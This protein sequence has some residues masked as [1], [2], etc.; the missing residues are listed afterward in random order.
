MKND[1]LNSLL[2]ISI[3]GPSA[4][5]KEAH[6]LLERVRHAYAN[7]KH[8]KIPQVNSIG[9]TDAS[10]ST[11]TKNNVESV[12]ENCEKETSW[13]KLVQPYFYKAPF[14]ISNFAEEEFYEEDY[15]FSDVEVA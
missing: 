11:Q 6:K 12:A 9:K 15:N 4:N 10:S 1:L 14:M 3:N 5:S 13:L 7:E 2:H 8:K